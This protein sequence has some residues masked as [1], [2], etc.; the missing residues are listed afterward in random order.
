M[1]IEGSEID[2]IKDFD[3]SKFENLI[4]EFHPGKTNNEEINSSKI[5]LKKQGFILV[6]KLKM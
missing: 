3:L 6:E 5:K 4:I 1:D 2:L